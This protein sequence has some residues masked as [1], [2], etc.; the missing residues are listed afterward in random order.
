M[1]ISIFSRFWL[2]YVQVPFTYVPFMLNG[3]HIHT[4]ILVGKPIK[5]L[6]RKKVPDKII[7]SKSLMQ[8]RGE[9]ERYHTRN[10]LMRQVQKDFLPFLTNEDVAPF[11]AKH[12]SEFPRTF[13]GT[14]GYSAF[15]DEAYLY[16]KRLRQAKVK[17]VLKNYDSVDCG[18]WR[19][20]DKTNSGKRMMDD[21]VEFIKEIEN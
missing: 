16:H 20:F 8:K 1:L 10:E 14:C 19:F 6:D 12:F 4:D 11:F 3:S 7:K 13:V 18:F 15:R 9:L 2:S 21:V 5:M 17:A